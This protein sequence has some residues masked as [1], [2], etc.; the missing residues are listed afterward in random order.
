[1]QQFTDSMVC[2]DSTD[3]SYFNKFDCCKDWAL[4]KQKDNVKTTETGIE[5]SSD[6]DDETPDKKEV[7][8]YQMGRHRKFNGL[9]QFG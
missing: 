6:K 1:M 7:T 3:N 8:W 4:F 2:E 5:C 9:Q